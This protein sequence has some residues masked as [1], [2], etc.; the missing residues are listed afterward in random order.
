[1]TH[2]GSGALAALPLVFRGGPGEGDAD[3][4]FKKIMSV[5]NEESKNPLAIIVL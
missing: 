4:Y 5:G 3:R 1:M 2:P